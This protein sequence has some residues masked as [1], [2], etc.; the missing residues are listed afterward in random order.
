MSINVSSTIA[1]LGVSKPDIVLAEAPTLWSGLPLLVKAIVPK[2][3]F[4]YVVHDIYPDVLFRL[5]VLRN[6]WL[7]NLIERVERIFYDR[8]ARVSVLSDGFKENLIRKGVPKDKIVIIPVCTDIEF[9]RPHPR[10]NELR[11][12]WG[13]GNKFVVLY[14]GNLGLSQGLD[15]VL[16]VARRV[17]DKPDILFVLVGDGA[18]KRALQAIAEVNGLSNVKFFPFQPREEVPLIYALADICLV[19]LKPDIVVE[20]VPSKTYTIMANGRP[21]IASVDKRTETGRLLDQ[22]QC[23]LCVEPGNGGALEQAIL[24]LYEND[25]LRRNMGRGGRDFV[26]EHYARHVAANQYYTLIQQFVNSN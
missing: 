5:G 20:S 19:A 9:F 21:V 12:R 11:K 13:L 17:I 26:V 25:S 16:E 6:P 4:I 7:V 24:L 14:A 3:P 15:T 23:G 8:S 2:V 1:A 22:A 10:D 18:T